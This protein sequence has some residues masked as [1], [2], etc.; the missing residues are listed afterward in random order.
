MRYKVDGSDIAVGDRVM[1]EGNVHG[2]VVC[3]FDRWQCLKGFE[4]WLTKEKLG[5]DATFSSG[6]MVKTEELGFLHYPDEDQSIL[7]FGGQTTID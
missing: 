6:V 2:L 1:V 3:D 5:D 4:S 7:K